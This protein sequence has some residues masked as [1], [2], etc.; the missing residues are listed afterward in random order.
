MPRV[1][2]VIDVT[3]RRIEQGEIDGI[4]AFDTLLVE[5]LTVREKRR[6]KTVLMIARL[7]AIK[8]RWPASTLAFSPRSIAIVSCR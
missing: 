2:E 7:T 6:V 1:I 3:C 8:R 4:E 5:E